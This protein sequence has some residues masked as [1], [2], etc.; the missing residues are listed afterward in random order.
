[1]TWTNEQSN[2]VLG[3]THCAK[4]YGAVTETQL[5]KQWWGDDSYGKIIEL[6]VGPTIKYGTEDDPILATILVVDPPAEFVFQWAP[7]PRW[8]SIA[9]TTRYLLEEENGGIRVTV[10]EEGFEKMPED[11]RQARFERIAGEYRMVMENLKAYLEE[12]SLLL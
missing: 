10:S 5:I 1:M 6:Q 4:I 7:H 9:M 3:L 11:V 8:Y 2:T 12:K